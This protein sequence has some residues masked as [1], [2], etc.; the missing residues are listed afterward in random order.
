MNTKK[1]KIKAAKKAQRRSVTLEG[2]E[3]ASWESLHAPGQRTMRPEKLLTPFTLSTT[4]A[5]QWFLLTHGDFM[6]DFNILLCIF[7]NE[8]YVSN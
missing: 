6:S 5:G 2:V 1:E 3:E 7:Y 8:Y 4:E